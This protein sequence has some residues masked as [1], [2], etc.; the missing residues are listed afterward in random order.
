MIAEFE[1][2]ASG[3]EPGRAGAKASGRVRRKQ[4]KLTPAQEAHRAHG[5]S[6]AG[7]AAC[8]AGT[9]QPWRKKLAQLSLSF[10]KNASAL[11]WSH[12]TEE[13]TDVW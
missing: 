9:R 6:G 10:L 13:P 11:S 5:R 2:D 3:C 7:G 8:C 12:S 4:P 1:S